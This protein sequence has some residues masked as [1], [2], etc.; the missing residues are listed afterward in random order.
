MSRRLDLAQRRPGD[1][2]RAIAKRFCNADTMERVIDPLIADL[3]F[4]HAKAESAGRVW[5]A[6]RIRLAGYLSFWRTVGLC[7]GRAVQGWSAAD[8]QAIGR[9]IGFAL[10]AT[11]GI[12]AV[13]VLLPFSNMPAPPTETSSVLLLAYLVPQALSA[14]IPF[15]LPIGLAIGTRGRLASRRVFWLIVAVAV[16]CTVVDLVVSGWVVPNTNQ[17][18]RVLV[19][20]RPSVARGANE[21]TLLELISRVSMAG[22]QESS[23]Q[24]LFSLH[25]RLAISVAPPILTCFAL[26]VPRL[27]WRTSFSVAA[28]VLASMLY[29]V[30]LV[31]LRPPYGNGWPPL[32]AAIWFPNILF[33]GLAAIVF[34]CTNGLAPLRQSRP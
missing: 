11:V 5:R 14:A 24:F 26:A 29:P 15:G 28:V 21:L 30:L 7:A 18:F 27:R 6:R 3:R 34:I 2:L 22:G 13:F 25:A 31:A 8:Q 19:S 1:R 17:A 32:W 10:A 20:G 9:T 23:R 12:T 33:L 16:G 4:E